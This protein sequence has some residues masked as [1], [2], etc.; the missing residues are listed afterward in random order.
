VP[1]LLDGNTRFPPRVAID[2]LLPALPALSMLT[3]NFDE[4]LESLRE[5]REQAIKLLADLRRWA[6]V[7]H[8]SDDTISA[9]IAYLER[10]LTASVTAAPLPDSRLVASS[11]FAS[12]NPFLITCVQP[13]V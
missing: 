5:W 8:L 6:T 3:R 10:S 11:M 4:G 2:V 7:N 1:L 12:P 9:R 13:S